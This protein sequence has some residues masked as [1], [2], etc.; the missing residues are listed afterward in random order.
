[1]NSALALTIIVVMSVAMTATRMI[2][3]AVTAPGL[4]PAVASMKV[5]PGLHLRRGIMMREGLQGTMITG[6]EAMMTADH[7]IIM[8]IVAGMTLTENA[9]IEDAMKKKTAT[10]TGLQ[11]PRPGMDGVE[12]FITGVWIRE[13]IFVIAFAFRILD[14]RTMWCNRRILGPRVFL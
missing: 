14:F 5:A 2:A 6:E 11:D 8:M 4:P 7:L 1:M 10:R 3:I 12:E 13:N 9:T